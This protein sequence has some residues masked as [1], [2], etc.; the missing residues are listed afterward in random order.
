MKMWIAKHERQPYLVLFK[1]KPVKRFDKFTRGW[2]WES[3]NMCNSYMTLDGSAFPSVTFENSPK[4]VELVLPS[5]EPTIGDL[6]NQLM[7]LNKE[8][9]EFRMLVGLMRH[10]QTYGD[11]QSSFQESAVDHFIKTHNIDWD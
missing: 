4:E 2:W 11:K 7:E 10:A 3:E 9:K 6:L 8:Y 1:E 5:Q